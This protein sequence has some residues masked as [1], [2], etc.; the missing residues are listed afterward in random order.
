M[1]FAHIH[2]LFYIWAIPLVFLICAHGMRRRRK[3]LAAFCNGD[4]LSVL[5]P[6]FSLKRRWVKYALILLSL[7]FTSLALSGPQYGFTWQEIQRKGVDLF[8]AIDCSKSMLASDI[9]PNRLE[10]AKREVFDLLSMLEGDRAGLVAFAGT[11]FVQCPLTL[12]YNAFHLFMSELGPDYLPLGG[13]DI[14]GAI[15]EALNG[16]P[17]NE[18]TEKALI[19]I[20]D[21]ESTG[22]DPL[23]AAKEAAKKGVKIFCIG[24]GNDDGI[25][26]PDADGGFKKDNQGKIILTRIDE[27]TLKDIADLTGG[28]YVRSV[29]GDMDLEEIYTRHIRGAMEQKTVSSGKKKIWEDRFQ[30]FL[31]PAIIFL[32]IG[33]GLPSAIKPPK[34]I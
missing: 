7:L 29:A 9:K 16:F 5:S 10:R 30:W 12:D 4:N 18:D 22:G 8:I 27:K 3:I 1:T 20:T 17:E 2:N 25:P 23:D 15:H 31:G 34:E 6:T 19:I 32:M 28:S 33:I 13:T 14:A 26:V 11:A 24:V 21:G